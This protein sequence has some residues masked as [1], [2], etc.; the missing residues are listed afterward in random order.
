MTKFGTVTQVREKHIST[1]SAM[2][3]FQVV[4]SHYV[5]SIVT[6]CTLITACRN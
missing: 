5:I 6:I 3:T 4:G 2:F 1:G